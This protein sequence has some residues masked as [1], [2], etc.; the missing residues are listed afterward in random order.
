MKLE[1]YNRYIKYL[2]DRGL[3]ETV[4]RFYQ[5]Y[6]HKYH[7]E[8][9]ER[10]SQI[11]VE[12]QKTTS[13]LFEPTISIVVPVYN[14]PV[15]YFESMISSVL[16]QTYSNWELCIADAS[17]KADISEYTEKYNDIRIKYTRLD[18]NFGISENTN[19]ALELATGEYIALL[20]HDDM[21]SVDA[22]YEVVKCIN[23]NNRPDVLYSDEDKV[24]DNSI[25]IDPYKKPDFNYDLLHGNN[26]ICHLFVVKR[27]VYEKTGGFRKEYDGAQDYDFIIRCIYHSKN[28]YHIN[29]V[30]YH[31]R[32]HDLSVAGNP[33]SKLYAYEAGKRAIKEWLRVEGFSGKV[34]KST[35][36]LGCYL[37]KYE[38]IE[39]PKVTV[40]IHGNVL[41]DYC[42]NAFNKANTYNNIE[43]LFSK[44]EELLNQIKEAKGDYVLLLDGRLRALSKGNIE[45]L[46]GICQRKNTACASGKLIKGNTILQAGITVNKNECIY[47]LSK[48]N[49][50]MAGYFY[51]NILQ[52]SVDAVSA[53]YMMI[54]KHL[55]KRYYDEIELFEKNTRFSYKNKNISDVGVVISQLLKSKGYYITVTPDVEIKVF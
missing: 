19:K 45:I 46:L 33:N 6:S 53:K 13:F 28:I 7:K 36:H 37:V 50:K 8:Y 38:S 27:E 49:K 39:K 42:M 20:D 3:K 22:L 17:D 25:H 18:K 5:K 29:K 30:L 44:N 24:L 32:I 14:V 48:K 34:L 11:N 43:I 16:K 1:K 10:I 21:L 47:D 2:K 35:K 4:N 26:Y 9:L 40:I 31:W 15:S 23:D 52:R 41:K 54:D 12:L 55:F 51:H